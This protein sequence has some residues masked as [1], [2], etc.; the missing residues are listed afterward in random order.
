MDHA[1]IGT[2]HAVNGHEFRSYLS[3]NGFVIPYIDMRSDAMI[4]HDSLFMF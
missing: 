1:I 4:R 2:G 3:C